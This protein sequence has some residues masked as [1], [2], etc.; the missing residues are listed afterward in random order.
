MLLRQCASSGCLTDDVEETTYVCSSCGRAREPTYG[1]KAS[2]G[3][4][5]DGGHAVAIPRDRE[6]NDGSRVRVA[7][8]CKRSGVRRFHGFHDKSD[9]RNRG[10]VIE[11]RELANWYAMDMMNDIYERQRWQRRWGAGGK[12]DHRDEF[13]G[14][15]RDALWADNGIHSYGTSSGD[16][17]GSGGSIGGGG[18]GSD[19][20]G[21]FS[22]GGGASASF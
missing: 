22:S 11:D 8:L 16:S 5:W 15:S 1:K 21:G 2:A 19:F 6:G 10:A 18:G 13:W 20:G 12:W 3:F 9:I 7:L 14:G 17:G 4:E